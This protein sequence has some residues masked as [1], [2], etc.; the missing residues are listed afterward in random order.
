I[1]RADFDKILADEAEKQGADIRYEHEI[2]AVDFEQEKPMVT[3]K[4][5][6]GSETTFSAE[7]ILDGSGYGRVLARLLDL[8]APVKTP[9]RG[10]LFTHIEDNITDERFDRNKILISVHPTRDDVWYWLIP[11]GNGRCSLGVVA[12][13]EYFKE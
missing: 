5:P 8:E 7:Y 1:Q 11:F 6:D 12:S 9:P 2:T 4:L 3:C 10:A 13:L